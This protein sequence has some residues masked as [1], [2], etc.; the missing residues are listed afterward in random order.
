MIEFDRVT[1]RGGDRGMSFLANGERRRKDDPLFEALGCL[2]E[3]ASFLGVVR[4]A[5][6]DSGRKEW[7]ETIR[8]IQERLLA[9]G[10]Q[11]ST[12]RQDPGYRRVKALQPEDLQRLEEQEK[13]LLDR[14][15]IPGRFI[16]P[17]DNAAAAHIDVA[18]AVCRTAE[19]RIVTCIRD[20]GMAHLAPCQVYLNRLSDYLFI[21]ARHLENG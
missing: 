11:M 16:L 18:R 2:D 3:L 19:R 13:A 1:T 12:P 14:T 9:I 17:G 5:L 7:P 20:Q 10:A 21:L 8:A 4:A 15:K 6:A